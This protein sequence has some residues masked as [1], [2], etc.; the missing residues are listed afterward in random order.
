[1]S[2]HM[3]IACHPY[4]VLMANIWTLGQGY[5]LLT[6]TNYILYKQYKN[7]ARTPC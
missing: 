4:G 6:L 2:K 7:I 3:S 1:M 5:L